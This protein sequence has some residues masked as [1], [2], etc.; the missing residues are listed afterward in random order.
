[1]KRLLLLLIC[2]LGAV[3]AAAQQVRLITIGPGDAFWSAYG[4]T[5]IAI[6]DEVYG[7]G[8]FS[9]DLETI[10]AFINNQM[11]YELGLSSSN[12]EHHLARSQNRDFSVITLDLEPAQVA[13]IS[14]YLQ[15]HYRPE[16]QTYRYDY[17]LQNCATKIRD[18]L[19]LAWPNRWEQDSQQT[20]E[21]SYF[22]LTFPA[23]HQGLMN[24]GLA[25]GYGPA[26]YAPRTDWELMAFPVHLERHLLQMG[27]PQVGERDLLF[28]AH[29]AQGLRY[30]WLTHWA[31]LSWLLLWTLLLSRPWVAAAKAWF[32][33]HGLIG[34]VLLA[35][36]WLTP[37]QV[38]AWNAN[39]LLFTPL[40]WF[41]AWWPRLKLAVGLGWL[42]WLLISVWLGAW[43]LLP[44]LLPAGLAWRRL[45]VPHQ[46]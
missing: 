42:L 10:K 24:L 6:D 37:H 45:S 26:A 7:F 36:W 28:D 39:I 35:G 17:F 46:T 44:L 1:M 31:L 18:L 40:G 9:F 5:A 11:M 27:L 2:V 43:Y 33:V 20:T 12:H 30:Y 29:H 19:I 4:H 41:T 32:W 21:S 16:N 23:R 13:A 22:D 38:M 34:V 25:M 8:Y 3:P 14:H 15:W